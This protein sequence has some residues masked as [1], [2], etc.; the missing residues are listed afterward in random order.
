MIEFDWLIHY[1]CNYRCPYCFFEGM[2]GE[3]E[4]RNRYLPHGTW[5]S[6][7][8]RIHARY[9]DL[10]VII[11]GGEPTIYPGFAELVAGLNGFAAV[12]FDTNLSIDKNAL[13]VSFVR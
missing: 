6:A 13:A 1:K 2:W 9:G 8:E 4:R 7:W 3:V 11:T 5:L 12:S 10:K